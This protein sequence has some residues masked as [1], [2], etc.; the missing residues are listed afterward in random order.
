VST[1]VGTA[2]L[3]VTNGNAIA[4]RYTVGATAGN[5]P[6]MRFLFAPPAG[7]LCQ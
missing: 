1:T 2:T 3:D 7:T 4:W 6:M 5:K